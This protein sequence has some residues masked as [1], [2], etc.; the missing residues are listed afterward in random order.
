MINTN[1]ININ[2]INA[3][4]EDLDAPLGVTFT[5]NCGLTSGISATF[6]REVSIPCES[7]CDA[8]VVVLTTVIVPLE[9]ET[10]ACVSAGT[11]DLSKVIVF[12]S[13]FGSTSTCD[14]DVLGIDNLTTVL[15]GTSTCAGQVAVKFDS[16]LLLEGDSL[17]PPPEVSLVSILYTDMEQGIDMHGSSIHYRKGKPGIGFNKYSVIRALGRIV[18]LKDEHI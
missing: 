10:L 1:L 8:A 6:T 7:L 14:S 12:E 2:I 9:A 13:D 15:T 5:G 4:A 3:P 16:S 11:T 17:M 18:I